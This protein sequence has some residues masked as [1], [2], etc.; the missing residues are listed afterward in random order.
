MATDSTKNSRILTLSDGSNTHYTLQ[1]IYDSKLLA[2]NPLLDPSSED[3]QT[4][5]KLGYSATETKVTIVKVTSGSFKY[6]VTLVN[7]DD[8]IGYLSANLSN[9]TTT[10]PDIFSVD[11]S[12]IS[13][14]AAPI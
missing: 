11:V 9:I 7:A 2:S 1:E 14:S 8:S 3:S 4:G 12:N 10:T 13:L 6:F 5:N